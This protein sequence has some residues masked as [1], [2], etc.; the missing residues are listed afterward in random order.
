[1]KS[2]YLMFFPSHLSYLFNC[3]DV[4]A[5][6]QVILMLKANTSGNEDTTMEECERHMSKCIKLKNNIFR[7]QKHNHISITFVL[8]SF[9]IKNTVFQTI[10]NHNNFENLTFSD[11]SNGIYCFSFMIKKMVVCGY[12]RA[13]VLQS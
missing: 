3:I 6:I 9:Q 10:T 1:M 12:V 8:I 2:E 13:N 7:R 11:I 5:Y 4:Y